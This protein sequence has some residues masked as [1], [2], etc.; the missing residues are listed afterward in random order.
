MFSPKRIFDRLAAAALLL[1]SAATAARA[2]VIT[3][4]TPD[5][6]YLG[7]TTQIPLQPPNY[8]TGSSY[9]SITDGT[10]R[11]DFSAVHVI[12]FQPSW[13]PHFLLLQNPGPNAILFKSW[14][15]SPDTE[16]YAPDSSPQILFSDF[17]FSSVL[18]NF[19]QPLSTFGMEMQP[20]RDS[21]GPYMIFAEFWGPG[22]YLGTLQLTFG[23]EDGSVPITARLL[24]M[25][26]TEVPITAV[27]IDGYDPVNG[28]P[29]EWGAARFRYEVATDPNA[30]PEPGTWALIA[31]GIAGIA[32]SKAGRRTLRTRYLPTVALLLSA[33][34]AAHASVITYTTPDSTYLNRTTIIPLRPPYYLDGF[35]YPSIS[36][37]NLAVNFQAGSIGNPTPLLLALATAGPMSGWADGWGSAPDTEGYDPDSS[38]QVLFP[39]Y[40]VSAVLMNFSRPLATF[41][42]EIQP[43]GSTYGPYIIT[44][45]FWGSGQYLGTAQLTFGSA[46]AIEP[47]LALLLAATS[48]G[49]PITAVRLAAYDPA[50]QQP[51]EWGAARFRYELAATGSEVPEPGTWTLLTAGFAGILTFRTSRRRH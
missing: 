40:A 43:Y 10:V 27:R 15:T 17:G 9:S 7:R 48:T 37:G 35:V 28:V 47:P 13:Q 38:P 14:G 11:V 30:V 32:V 20:F 24:A 1:L 36:D 49:L 50:N 19:N 3:Y 18:L 31:L 8:V 34:A 39:G 44:A 42:F 29:L 21:G 6:T 5:P 2:N 25:T 45:E 16:G 26:S 41:G 12:Q 33:A 22:I 23:S 46:D 51:I 4:T